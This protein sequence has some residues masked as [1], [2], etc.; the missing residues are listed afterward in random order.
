MNPQEARTLIPITEASKV[1]D[2]LRKAN[3][4]QT[5][6]IGRLVND[7]EAKDLQIAE[8]TFELRQLKDGK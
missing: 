7:L 3:E 8:L 4:R 2:K 6:A 5:K 1:M